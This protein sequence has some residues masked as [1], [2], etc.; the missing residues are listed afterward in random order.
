LT[1]VARPHEQRDGVQQAVL[2]LTATG[3]SARL[4][5]FHTLEAKL[6]PDLGEGGTYRERRSSVGELPVLGPHHDPVRVTPDVTVG[7]MVLLLQ[8]G[9]STSKNP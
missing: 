9:H 5:P 1:G 8:H 3:D 2:L 4:F 7:V 6:A